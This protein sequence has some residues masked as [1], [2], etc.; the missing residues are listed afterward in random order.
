MIEIDPHDRTDLTGSWA[1]FGFQ[2]GHMFTP[3]VTSWNPA[4]WPGGP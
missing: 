4:I 2:A 3:R 1:G